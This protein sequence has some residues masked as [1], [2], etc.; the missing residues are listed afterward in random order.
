[1]TSINN[2]M[3]KNKRQATYEQQQPVSPHLSVSHHTSIS[4]WNSVA[5]YRNI[6]GGGGDDDVG[7]GRVVRNISS[8]TRKSTH[9]RNR[10]QSDYSV[11][12]GSASGEEGHT[13]HGLDLH[14]VN[15]G[16]GPIWF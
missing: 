14:P 6:G 5:H 9:L 11:A 1:M 10:K 4:S 16:D 3:K 15:D 8:S 13:Q 12:G 7:S 2:L